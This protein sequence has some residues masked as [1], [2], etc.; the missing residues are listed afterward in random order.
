MKLFEGTCILLTTLVMQKARV[1]NHNSVGSTYVLK[2]LFGGT[3]YMYG[4][5]LNMFLRSLRTR[6]N[7]CNIMKLVNILLVCCLVE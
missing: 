4:V 1:G 2:T 7:G 5:I 3:I 6:C